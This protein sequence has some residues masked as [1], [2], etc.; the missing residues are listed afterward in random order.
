MPNIKLT[1][2]APVYNEEEVIGDFH[3]RLCEVLA[4]LE[5]VDAEIL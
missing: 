3:I 1:V 4:T 5:K 2:I